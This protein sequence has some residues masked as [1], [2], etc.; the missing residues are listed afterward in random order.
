MKSIVITSIYIPVVNL[1]PFLFSLYMLGL[2]FQAP[3]LALPRGT[4]PG[5]KDKALL[6]GLHL[7]ASGDVG[8]VILLGLLL[9]AKLG[10]GSECV[11]R[12]IRTHSPE[13]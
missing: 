11:S 1:Y 8:A 9:Q 5:F 12:F 2:C 3:S 4:V 10:A 6:R 7:E 13:R